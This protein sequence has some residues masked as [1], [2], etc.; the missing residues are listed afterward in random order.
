MSMFKIKKGDT[1]KV[2][3]SRGGRGARPP[4]VGAAIHSMLATQNSH[5]HFGCLE[6]FFLT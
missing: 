3:V 5:R 4:G 2:I 1:V 6:I